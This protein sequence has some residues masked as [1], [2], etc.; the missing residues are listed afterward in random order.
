MKKSRNQRSSLIFILCFT[1]SLL[2]VHIPSVSYGTEARIADFFITNNSKD[3]L[4]Y[5]RVKECFTKQMDEAILAGIPTTFTFLLELQQER[6]LWF[7][8]SLSRMEIKHTIKY[9][10][11]RN[12]FFVTFSEQG[13]A[14]HVEFKDFASAK[15]AMADI[16]GIAIAPLK[17]LKRD[18]QY[19]IK[20]KAKLDKVRLPLHMEYVFFFVSMWDFETEWYRH[21]FVYK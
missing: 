4:V 20:V 3:I 2:L 13:A 15:R 11:V 8:S 14:S 5:F 10:N 18:S 9:D 1:I 7:D 17:M 19:F 21:G 12:V 16:N 6:A